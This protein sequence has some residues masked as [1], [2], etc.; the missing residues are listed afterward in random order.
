ML[1]GRS[2]M[3][4]NTKF[5]LRQSHFHEVLDNRTSDPRLVFHWNYDRTQIKR[6]KQLMKDNMKPFKKFSFIP[7]F[8]K[9]CKNLPPKKTTKFYRL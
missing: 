2:D 1:Q 5:V 7:G 3:V 8:E 9:V 4:D 6:L